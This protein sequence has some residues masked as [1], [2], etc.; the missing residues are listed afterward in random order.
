M[1]RPGLRLG[2]TGGIGSGKSTVAGLFSGLGAVVIDTDRIAHEL[3]QPGGAAME[4]IGQ[5]FGADVIDRQGAL[6]RARM[7]ERVFAD[8]AVKA[9]L[10]AILHPM[11]ALQTQRLAQAAGPASAIVFDVP[12]LVESQ[13]WRDRVDKVLVVDCA[14]ETQ[15]QR[16]M[17][18]SG[19]TRHA[20]LAV[21]ERQAARA[22][23]RAC[24][25]AV[26][27]NDGLS[28]EQ[29]SQDVQALW[30]RWTAG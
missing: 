24:A 22:L 14:Q 29:L 16:V 19:W 18:R 28:L 5:V 20:V 30:Q 11:I 3:T 23:R 13:H 7:R 17:A 26:I 25:D 4:R 10:E 15:V 12:L 2:L 27:S 6:D 1:S 21:I 8:G 9:Q